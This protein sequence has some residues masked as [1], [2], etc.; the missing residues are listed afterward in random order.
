LPQSAAFAAR[1]RA[2]NGFA[3]ERLRAVNGFAGERLRAVNG[4]AIKSRRQAAAPGNRSGLRPSL[5]GGAA[6]SPLQRNGP[7]ARA[8]PMN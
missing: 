2:V 8:V 7:V 5:K 4:F 3:G 6:W 1:L